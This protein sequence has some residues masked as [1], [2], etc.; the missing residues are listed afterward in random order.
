MI[1]SK[2]HDQ[3]IELRTGFRVNAH[4]AMLS[5]Y[6]GIWKRRRLTSPKVH[7][8]LTL[9]GELHLMGPRRPGSAHLKSS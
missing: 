7:E 4:A 6:S 8:L 3:M 9:T 5:P 1:Q 2:I